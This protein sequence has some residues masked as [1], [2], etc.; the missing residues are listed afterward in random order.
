[1]EIDFG[2]QNDI[3]AT[4]DTALQRDPTRMPS[5]HFDHDDPPMAGRRSV[6]PVQ[7]VHN[8]INRRIEAE[9]GCSR[10]EVVVDRVRIRF[11]QRSCSHAHPP[12]C[13]EGRGDHPRALRSIDSSRWGVFEL[14]IKS[15]KFLWISHPTGSRPLIVQLPAALH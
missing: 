12:L 15:E 2:N 11:R 6:Q 13:C 9:R 14:R 10:F 8:D 7:R 4:G 5:H 1:M 3:G